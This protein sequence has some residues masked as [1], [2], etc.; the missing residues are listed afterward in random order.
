MT[1]ERLRRVLLGWDVL[2]AY[3]LLAGPVVVGAL[4]TS[5]L[6]PLA[7]PGYLALLIGSGVGS[8]LFPN[9]A[10]WVFW[11]PFFLGGYAVSVAVAAGYRA[12]ARRT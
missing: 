11:V 4:D 8:V 6:T 12:L 7:L 2:A 9:L 1:P 10:L 5:L 3:V